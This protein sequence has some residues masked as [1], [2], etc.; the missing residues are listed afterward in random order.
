MKKRKKPRGTAWQKK[1]Q[2]K[3]ADKTTANAANA[4]SDTDR[5]IF[6]ASLLVQKELKEISANFPQ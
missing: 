2:K 6:E 4:L 5:K 1:T 3:V